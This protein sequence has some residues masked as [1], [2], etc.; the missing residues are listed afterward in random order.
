MFFPAV[1]SWFPTP[2][3]QRSVVTIHD[4]IPEHFPKQVF[5]GWKDRFFWKLKV[6]LALWQSE[7]VMTV[8]NAAK[9]EIIEYIKVPESR[10]DVINEA[11][12]E[13]FIKT[14]D[15]TL[16][17]RTRKKY[18]IPIDKRMIIYVGG[19]A[20]Y[21]NLAAFLEAFGDATQN[22]ALSDVHLIL[23]GDQDSAGFHSNQ[24]SLQ[25]RIRDSP[26]LAERVH[27]TGYVPD[28]D[29]VAL[30]NDALAAAMP[31]YSEGFG[32]PAIEAMACGTPVLSSN[33]GA[34]PEVVGDTG[35]YFDPCDRGAMTRAIIDMATEP[36]LRDELA[37][38]A[39]RRASTFTWE[40][41]AKSALA[42]I[43]A[44]APSG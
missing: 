38:R 29:L 16:H 11:P 40:K 36:A 30:Y 22:A 12:S 18:R 32:L 39:L 10:I 44:A 1:Y 28:E 35:L 20:P 13:I 43:E 7:R 33:R 17:G 41:A 27:F 4:A 42:H 21:K 14:D 2:H 31:S 37:E 26:G 15:S 24:A 9:A 5:P 8:S 25:R 3:S 6:R 34:L 19:F 23:V